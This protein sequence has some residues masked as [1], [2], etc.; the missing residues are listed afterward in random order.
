LLH[1]DHNNLGPN[2]SPVIPPNGSLDELTSANLGIFA[3]NMLYTLTVSLGLENNDPLLDVGLA[4]GTGAPT[5]ADVFPAPG[6]PSF[7]F[8]LING[9]SPTFAPLER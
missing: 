4:L 2:P 8:A 5:L 1:L 6:Q 3:A 7:A 9:A